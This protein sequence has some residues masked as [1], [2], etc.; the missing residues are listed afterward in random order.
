M[1]TP[2]LIETPKGLQVTLPQ[3]KRPFSLSFT[4]ELDRRARQ[5]GELLWRATGAARPAPPLILDATAGLCRDAYLLASGGAQVIALERE[6]LLYQLTSEALSRTS[7]EMID[8]LTLLSLDAIELLSGRLEGRA[9]PALEG[10]PWPFGVIYLDPMFP[11]R[12]KSAAVSREAQVLQALTHA[13]VRSEEERLA[14]EEALLKLALK[15]VYYRVVVKRPLKAPPLPG[16]TPSAS[17]KGK[18]IRFDIYGVRSLQV[19][20]QPAHLEADR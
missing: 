16:P 19:P 1:R 11:A 20:Y 3:L 18:A 15:S 4:G 14:E 5:G 7:G 2:E 9:H 17:L 13:L 6:P 10:F 8:R 12:Q